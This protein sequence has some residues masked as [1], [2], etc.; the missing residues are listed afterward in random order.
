M[1]ITPLPS[2]PAVTDTTAQFNTKAFEWVAALADFTNE[3]NALASQVDADATT[4]AEGAEAAAAAVAAAN[5]KGEWSTLTGALNIPASVSHNSAVWVLTENLA[6][7][8]T[9]EPGVNSP[10]KWL[11]VTLPEQAGNAGKFLSTDGDTPSWETPPDPIEVRQPNNV[12]PANAVTGIGP[13]PTLTGSTYYDI[14]GFTKAASQ[15]QI[16]TS[17]TFSTTI[18]DTGDIAGTGL[19]YTVSLGTLSVSTTYYWRVRYKN[20]NGSYSI[21]SVPT[22]FT[23]AS[24]FGPT[25]IGQSYGGGYY[26]GIINDGGAQ[27]YLI[28]APKASG[29]TSKVIY[30]YNA[31]TTGTTYVTNGY[32]NTS[33]YMNYYGDAAEAP[34]FTW[35]LTVNG[36]S[37][38]YLPAKNELEIIYYNLKPTTTSNNTSSGTNT[39]AVPS[40]G[41]NYTASVPAR[42][43]A[44]AFQSGGSEAFSASNYWSS[45]EAFSEYPN[46]TNWWQSFDTGQQSTSLK[47]TVLNVRAIRKLSFNWE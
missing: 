1:S 41:S 21:W 42:T 45:T 28:V 46:A 27:Y 8:T 40:R 16:S 32:G 31:S 35:N 23:T 19:T 6:N 38:W 39:N 44:A 22:T 5:Y 10:S 29:E 37:D 25:V 18:L 26:A 15:F 36:Y 4:A 9:D 13:T 11:L 2:A 34:Y 20:S 17:S 33:N 24:A 47:N 3:V 7:V 30:N 14:Y 43:T 12:S